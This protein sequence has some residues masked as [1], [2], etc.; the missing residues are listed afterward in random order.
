[1]AAAAAPV[2]DAG[3]ARARQWIAQEFTPSTLSPAQQL[4]ELRWFIDA[5]R[6]YRGMTIRVV[7]ET[8]PTHLYESAVLA[9]AFSDITGI[10]VI[11]EV[12]GEDDVVKK[13][14]THMQTGLPL[15]DAYVNDS[16]FIGTHFRKGKTLVLSD[17]MADEGKAVTLP[18]LDLDDFIGLRFTTG[19]D[20]K[21][22]QLPDQQFANLYWYRHDWFT[23]P[24]LQSA[25]EARYGYPLGVP[26]NWTA[27]EDIAEFFTQHVRELDGKP[28]W[29]HM[30][31]GRT[32]PSLGWRFSDAWLSMAGVGD[33]G[34]P[35][36]HPVDEWG[37]RVD[38]CVPVG[39]SV[40]RGGALDGP[41]A[42]YA[43]RQ[44]KRWLD[45]FAPPEAR[46]LTFNSAAEWVPKGQIAQQIFWYTAFVPQV[47]DA[48]EVLAYPDGR[49][50]WRVAP[51]PVGAYWDEGMKSGYQDAGS[52][53]LLKDTA[54]DRKAAAWLYAQFT[55]SKTVSLRKTLV[56]LTPIRKSD[57]LA[58]AM[59]EM[60]PRLGGL[61]E[62]YRS[63]ARDVW[64]P[65]GTNVPDYPALAAL[66]W[67]HLSPVIEG[68]QSVEAGIRSLAQAMDR[69]LDVL[70]RSGEFEQCAPR[71]A[72]PRDP[73]WWLA[74][75][76]APKAP[77]DERPPG[78]T[79]SY[80]EAIRQWQ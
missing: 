26:Q 62:F 71:L 50:R 20:G 63:R 6:P 34:L 10:H 11:H 57:L 42:H 76:G 45:R 65:T 33:R 75:P 49:A 48:G 41:A 74:Q 60:A 55:V 72:E 27:Y 40:A 19:P 31:Y 70:G 61:V 78:R 24:D 59:T 15:Y 29:G 66:W 3:L 79:L 37:I 38:G 35:N 5:A 9:K 8:I 23:R 67:Q 56:G 1:M 17:Y 53:T 46:T 58:P 54:P 25:F 21:L 47:L 39:A 68:V 36:G 16:D 22:Y 12:T 28:V 7:S 51:S 69:Q 4:D 32:D 30:D 64:T 73:A 77:R 43:I 14:Q 52:W 44:Y 18:T 2:E 13:L 80:E